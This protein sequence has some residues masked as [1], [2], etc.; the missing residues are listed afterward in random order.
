MRTKEKTLL[1]Q[2]GRVFMAGL[3]VGTLWMAS[4]GCWWG[5]DDHHEHDDW[6]HD[7]PDWDHDHRLDH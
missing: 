5:H 6:H 3:V 2:L 1:E 7:H 4:A